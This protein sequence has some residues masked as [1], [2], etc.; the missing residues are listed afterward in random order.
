MFHVIVCSCS[1]QVLAHHVGSSDNF[2]KYFSSDL[3][4]LYLT[5]IFDMDW[6]RKF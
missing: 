3:Y 5:T 2:E 6:T 1:K 4:L